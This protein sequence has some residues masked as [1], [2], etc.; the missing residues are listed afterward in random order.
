MTVKEV[1]EYYQSVLNILCDLI[2]DVTITVL[3]AVMWV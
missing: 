1:Q 3:E 2:F